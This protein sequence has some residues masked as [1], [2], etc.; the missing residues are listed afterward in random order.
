MIAFGTRYRHYKYVVLLFELANTPATFQ[1]F[2]KNALQ[3][4][5][6]VS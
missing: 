3:G 4:F 2:I 1:D 5:L 6:D